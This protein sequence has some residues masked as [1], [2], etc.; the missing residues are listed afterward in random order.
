VRRNLFHRTAPATQRNNPSPQIFTDR[1]WHRIPT[2]PTTNL[3][4]LYH[5]ANYSLSAITLL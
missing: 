4:L 1:S 5:I 3:C 2:T